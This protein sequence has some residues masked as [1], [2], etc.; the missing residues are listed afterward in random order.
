MIYTYEHESKEKITHR[1]LIDKIMNNPSMIAQDFKPIRKEVLVLRG[2][3][4]IVGKLKE[5]FCLV[6]VKVSKQA[7]LMIN[8]KKQL[9]RYTRAINQYCEIFQFPKIEFKYIVVRKLNHILK[10]NIYDSEG[11]L[12][13]ESYVN[14]KGYRGVVD[15]GKIPIY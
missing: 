2:T 8:A 13:K 7:M 1:D 12:L 11:D 14:G 6:E 5:D 9:A 10:I 4:D 3:V 15:D